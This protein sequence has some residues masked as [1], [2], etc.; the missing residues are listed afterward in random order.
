M[1]INKFN[2]KIDNK[3]INSPTKFIVQGK[4]K[5]AKINKKKPTHHNGI[6]KNKAL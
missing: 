5:L 6:K 1:I 2:F 4:P 3:I